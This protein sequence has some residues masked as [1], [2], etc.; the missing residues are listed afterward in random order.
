MP[1][2]FEDAGAPGLGARAFA[3]RRMPPVVCPLG[4]AAGAILSFDPKQINS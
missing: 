4:I 3:G 2:M 1:T